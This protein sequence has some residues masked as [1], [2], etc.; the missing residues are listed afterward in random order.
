MNRDTA[1][2]ASD[3]N[4]KYCWLWA[5]R[6]HISLSRLRA[7]SG[8]HGHEACASVKLSPFLF[9]FSVQRRGANAQSFGGLGAI[10]QRGIRES[11]C[12]TP[13][14]DDRLRVST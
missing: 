3:R 14:P 4:S 9:Q 10:R 2:S 13:E 12:A 8:A 11:L 6:N 5:P 1:Y 7:D